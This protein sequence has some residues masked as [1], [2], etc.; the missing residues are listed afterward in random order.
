MPRERRY[1][2]RNGMIEPSGAGTRPR[3][4]MVGL[5]E[6]FVP[7]YATEIP[8]ASRGFGHSVLDTTRLEREVGGSLPGWFDLIDASLLGVSGSGARCI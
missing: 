1:D 2:A 4:R 7:V 3:K 8:A 5:S 6:R